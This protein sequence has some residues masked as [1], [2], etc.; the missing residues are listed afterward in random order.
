VWLTNTTGARHCNRK[1]T[2]LS[3][4]SQHTGA[5]EIGQYRPQISRPWRPLPKLQSMYCHRLLANEVHLE[6]S[7][8]SRSYRVVYSAAV[9]GGVQQH[10]VLSQVHQ[11]RVGLEWQCTTC[12]RVFPYLAPSSYIPHMVSSR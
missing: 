12:S 8:Q 3:K 1:V 7:F 11:S 4:S 6:T 2:V 10:G 5:C 9:P